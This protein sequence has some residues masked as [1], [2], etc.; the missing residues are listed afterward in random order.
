MH[1][2]MDNHIF[3]INLIQDP[4]FTFDLFQ[5]H[6]L[7]SNITMAL[8]LVLHNTWPVNLCHVICITT[9]IYGLLGKAPRGR[10]FS[11]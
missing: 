5:A 6:M 2:S 11:E 10:A 1:P 8:V 7:N 9:E 3:V 4:F